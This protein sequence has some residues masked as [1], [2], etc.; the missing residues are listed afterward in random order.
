MFRDFEINSPAPDVIPLGPSQYA[1]KKMEDAEYIE[2][3]YFTVEGCREAN[4]ATPST[5]DDTF[6]LLT[7]GDNFTLQPTRTVKGSLNAVIDEDLT[8]DQIM[9]ARH[10]F[11]N[12]AYRMGW[13]EKFIDSISG[14]YSGLESL[15]ALGRKTP[16][17]IRY[18]ARVR[19]CWYEA[20]RGRGAMFDISVINVNL[21]QE[22]QN[23]MRDDVQEVLLNNQASSS[24]E[25]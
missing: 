2:L 18:H 11:V 4:K 5:I 15:K 19:K 20:M 16:A 7:T 13:P 17:L 23:E 8:W 12:I 25:P 21:L 14:L 24:D 3:W 6:N 1:M 10:N 9:T 22:V